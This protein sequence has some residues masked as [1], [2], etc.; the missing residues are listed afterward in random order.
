MNWIWGL[1]NSTYIALLMFVPFVNFIMFFVLGAKGSKWAWKN[2]LWEDE[3]HFI[4]TQRN[5]AIAGL[6]LP[7]AFLLIMV[8]ITLLLFK[9]MS[10]ND[11]YKMSLATVQSDS[12]IIEAMGDPIEPSWLTTGSVH[13]S[14]SNGVADLAFSISGPKCKGKVFSYSK[15]RMGEWEVLKLIVKLNCN[16][17]TYTLIGRDESKSI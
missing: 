11:A 13:T 4:K 16:S 15:R 2:R 5:W 1:G 10:N 12:R 9:I 8:P 7:I 17:T 6:A 14:G 3:E